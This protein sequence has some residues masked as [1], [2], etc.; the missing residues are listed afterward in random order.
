MIDNLR[1]FISGTK[2]MVKWNWSGVDNSIEATCSLHKR[3]NGMEI[4]SKKVNLAEYE[5]EKGGCVFDLPDVPVYIKLTDTQSTDNRG[6]LAVE[7]RIVWESQPYEVIAYDKKKEEDL[8]SGFFSKKKHYYRKFVMEFPKTITDEEIKK[9]VDG[10]MIAASIDPHQFNPFFLP[11]PVGRTTETAW[12]EVSEEQYRQKAQFRVMEELLGDMV[13]KPQDLKFHRM[14]SVA[15]E[16]KDGKSE[17]CGLDVKAIDFSKL[18]KRVEGGYYETKCPY[19][20]AKIGPFE[21]VFRAR[22]G[23]NDKIGFVAETDDKY[24]EWRVQ[25]EMRK[26]NNKYGRVL[27]WGSGDISEVFYASDP[28]TAVPYKASDALQDIVIAVKDAK[29]NQTNVKLCPYCHNAIPGKICKY[30]S[31]FISMMG[32]TGSGK[33]VYMASM[34]HQLESKALFPGYRFKCTPCP[35]KS[36][37][38]IKDVYETKLAGHKKANDGADKTAGRSAAVNEGTS[39]FQVVADPFESTGAFQPIFAAAPA[40][41]APGA[42]FD[43]HSVPAPDSAN[44]M[45]DMFAFSNTSFNAVSDKSADAEAAPVPEQPADQNYDFDDGQTTFF[46]TV[47]TP[48]GENLPKATERVYIEPYIYEL[49]GQDPITHDEVG[50][51]LSFFD[52]PGEAIR[53]PPEAPMTSHDQYLEQMINIADGLIFMFDPSTL[54]IIKCMEENEKEEFTS[55]TLPGGEQKWSY[56]LNQDPERILRDFEN[57]YFAASEMDKP[58]AFVLSKADVLRDYYI[59]MKGISEQ[60]VSFLEESVYALDSERTGVYESE[61]RESSNR[62]LDFINENGL[63]AEC[64][65]LLKHEEDGVW[66]CVSSTGIAPDKNGTLYQ[67]HGVPV[68]V[69][70]AVEWIIYRKA[71]KA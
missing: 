11:K 1:Y 32:D 71:L 70:D 67:M 57:T 12:F 10:W 25:R 44:P 35:N 4:V 16:H 2:L 28:F 19:C 46:D 41:S 69:I 7:Q 27:E 58:V 38:I 9:Y 64:A 47:E 43:G 29:K 66:M 18:G 14:F 31:L 68:H 23:Q 53:R 48:L 37:Q 50:V 20:F 21:P 24:E 30:P 13:K 22:P 55:K 65:H 15:G 63:R 62:I 33:T 40:A 8:K 54:A 56:T 42:P 45:F 6:N 26:S 3:I 5:K 34:L 51:I 17:K 52:F 36:W 39:G 49:V 59:R 60:D 61:F